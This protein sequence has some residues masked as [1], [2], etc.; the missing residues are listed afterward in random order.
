[1]LDSV[2][3][4]RDWY[5]NVIVP[6]MPDRPADEE[7]VS[8]PIIIRQA[9]GYEVQFNVRRLKH[10]LRLSA[11]PLYVKFESFDGARS[12]HLEYEMLADNVPKPVTG[13]LHVIISRD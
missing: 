4:P 1:M 10:G 11:D 7:N 9:S 8:A 12:F 13:K 6:R 2:G 3:V 5:D